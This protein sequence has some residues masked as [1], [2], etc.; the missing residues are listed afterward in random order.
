[1]S[2]RS[3]Y[4]AFLLGVALSPGCGAAVY[5]VTKA[6][7]KTAVKKAEAAGA[8]EKDPYHYWRAVSYLEKSKEEAGYSDFQPAIKYS[9][10]AKESALKAAETSKNQAKRR[11][12]NEK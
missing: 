4:L 3:A 12:P 7:A 11:G 2:R 1:M 10:I 5:S 9:R 6:Q 8:P